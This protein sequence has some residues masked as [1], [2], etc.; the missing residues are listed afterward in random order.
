MQNFVLVAV[1]H[2][3]AMAHDHDHHHDH[4]HHHDHEHSQVTRLQAYG[5]EV[6]ADF[7]SVPVVLAVQK[8]APGAMKALEKS[9]EPFAGGTVRASAKLATNRWA[10]RH[11]IAMNSDAYQQ[12]LDEIY[13]HEMS[14]L[15][16]AALWTI[17]SIGINAL[18]QRTLGVKHTW[19]NI[20]SG[21]AVGAVITSGL[22][23][24][25]RVISPSSMRKWDQF[26]TKHLIAPATRQMG[27]VA[28]ISE[29]AIEKVLEEQ[30]DRQGISWEE[31]S[32]QNDTQP[33]GAMQP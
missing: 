21:K 10:K 26:T 12:H 16:H 2:I 24:G 11:G 3:T 30:A 13:H 27:K 19:A 7:G 5:A 9:I 6:I 33:Q 29:Q 14:H 25:A 4:H 23:I 31:R 8:Y 18:A 15:P 22:V 1:V 17:S 32:C 28:G 20:L